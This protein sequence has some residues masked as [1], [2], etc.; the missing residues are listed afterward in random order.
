MH[1][2]QFV[3]LNA[4]D[5]GV[6]E[7]SIADLTYQAQVLDMMDLDTS[8]KLQIHVGGVYGNKTASMERF[9]DNYERLD[10]SVKRRLVIENDERLY[11]ISDCLTLNERTGIPVL[12]DV[13]HH[14]INNNG[15]KIVDLLDPVN[16]TWKTPDGIP[17][18]DYSSQQA[19]KRVGA[20]AESIN[21]KDFRFFLQSTVP[22][23]MD[24]MLEIKDKEKS[25]LIALTLA[26]DDSRLVI[27][28]GDTLKKRGSLTG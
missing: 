17:M 4:P 28:S 5:R 25:A 24:I 7:R 20:H 26:R 22:F 16:A 21:K 2:D 1:P 10:D 6:L 18:A 8:A 15:E 23:D 27:G 19:G 14:A 3:L 13:F 12:V 9:V 11:T